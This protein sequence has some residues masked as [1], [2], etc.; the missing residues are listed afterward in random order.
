MLRDSSMIAITE[1]IKGSLDSLQRP[2]GHT[3]TLRGNKRKEIGNL[4]HS[5][6]CSFN[7]NVAVALRFP[8]N[9]EEFECFTR[10][11]AQVHQRLF[12][13]ALYCAHL[14]SVLCIVF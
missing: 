9:A 1:V 14:H 4:G 6:K 3:F 5:R 11:T 8:D 12:S 2:R 10:T 13:Y 7:K